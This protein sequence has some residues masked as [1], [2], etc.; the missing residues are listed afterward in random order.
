MTK[1]KRLSIKVEKDGDC[2]YKALVGLY[3]SQG[4]FV[5]VRNQSGFKADADAIAWGKQTIIEMQ[6]IRAERNAEIIKAK[7][8]A[9]E[10]R[11]QLESMTFQDLSKEVDHDARS[12]LFSR[13]AQLYTEYAYMEFRNGESE[14]QAYI[15]AEEAVGRRN[16]VRIIKA[17]SGELD[18]ILKEVYGA[19]LERARRAA[20]IHKEIEELKTSPFESEICK[21][22]S[23][24]TDIVGKKKVTV[25]RNDR[26]VFCVV[27]MDGDVIGHDPSHRDLFRASLNKALGSGGV[28]IVRQFLATGANELCENGKTLWIP[29]KNIYGFILGGNLGKGGW[30][31][32]PIEDLKWSFSFNAE[33]GEPIPPEPH[34]TF[35]LYEPTGRTSKAEP[36]K[37]LKFIKRILR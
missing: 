13:A 8:Q 24:L 35:C 36:A 2:S 9:R 17:T 33:T 25:K 3:R 7:K 32:I 22:L 19:T 4:R 12:V 29:D 11:K 37:V 18:R 15:L 14:E 34:V 1:K 6:R 23:T 10:R 21:I 28:M 27:D 5:M 26:Q 31:S 30:E 20:G 16:N